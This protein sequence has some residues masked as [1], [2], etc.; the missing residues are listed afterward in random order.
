MAARSHTGQ[1]GEYAGR[2]GAALDRFLCSPQGD[3]MSRHADWSRALDGPL[4]DVGIGAEGVLEELE[5]TVIPNGARLSEPGFWG[6]ITAGPTSI[7]TVA[8]L[9]ASVAS[10]QRYTL[11]AFN[12]LEERSLEWLAQLCGL[13]SAM[14]GVYSSGGSV[15][16]LIALGAAR[17]AAFEAAASTRPPTASARPTRSVRLR[18]SPPR[19]PAGRR[20]ARAGP[21]QRAPHRD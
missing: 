5:R 4:P 6:W 12:L 13:F 1:L 20:R 18:R 9:A 15:A 17:Q 8:A 14:K 7:P 16:N 21:A 11:T 3:A 10:P 2:I 19:H